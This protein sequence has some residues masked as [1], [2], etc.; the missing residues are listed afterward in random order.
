MSYVGGK[1]ASRILGVH[2]RTLYQWDEKGWIETIRT[3]GG[4]RLYNVKKYL[5]EKEEENKKEDKLK[6]CYIRVSSKGQSDDLERQR[7]YMERKY[8]NHIIYS[9]IGSGLN[10]YRKK[11]NKII[12]LAIDGKI[13]EVVVAYKDRLARFGYDQ[14][15]RIIKKYSNGTIVVINERPEKEKMEEIVEDTLQIMNVMTAM[16]NGLR[17]YA[18]KEDK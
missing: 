3:K 2:Q 12:D 18:K 6:I 9:D 1:E 11:L 17:K 13:D 16:M 10:L 5:K 14:I 4:K 8:P 15:E 7:K